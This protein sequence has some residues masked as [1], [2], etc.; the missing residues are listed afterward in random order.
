MGGVR[1]RTKFLIA[2]LLTSAG[3]TIGTL[4]VVQHTVAVRAREGIVADLQNSVENFRA[5]QLEREKNLRASARLLA[6]LPIVKALMTSRHAPTIQ[7][8]SEELFKLSERDLFALVDP[9]GQVVGF[10]T[11][12]A[13]VP[14]APIQ[15]V[16]S[17]RAPTANSF[18]WWYTGGHLYEVYL[19]PIY[20][21]PSSNDTLLGVIAVG[22]EIN[23][24]LA[25]QVGRLA[26]SEVA[27]LYRGNVVASTLN[28]RPSLEFLQHTGSSNSSPADVLLGQKKFVATSIL[29][30]ADDST[31]VTMV[32]MKSYDNAISFLQRLQ[33]LLLVI[34]IAAVLAG[35]ILVYFIARTFTR[36]LETLAVGV[37]ALGTGDFAFPLPGGGGGEVV[38]LTQAFVDMRDRLRAT[39][40]SLI[41]SERLATIGRMAG[42]ISHDLRHPLTAVLANAEFLAE[43]NLNTTQREELYMEIRVAVNRLTDLVDSLL[44]LSR[45]AQALTL[46][47]GPIEGSILRSIELIRAHPE[48]HKVSIEVE[49]AAGVD[50][51]VDGRK[52]ERVFYNLLLNA[53]Q[54]VQS[55]A[56]KVVISV[57]ES[58][59]GVEIRVR[60]NG[61]GVEPSIATKLFQPFVSVG[62]ENGTGLGLTIAQKIVQDHGGSLEV[63]WSSPGNTVMRIVLPQPTR[64]DRWRAPLAKS[65]L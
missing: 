53:C 50:T 15:H 6:D 41:E 30:S 43:A 35:S 34:G 42:S 54:A 8:A 38:K 25:R 7:D 58:S 4:L 12:P 28:D 65:S 5:E 9:T 23:G 57:T 49:G 52:M 62:K 33:R 17:Q 14:S 24:P 60:D 19:E 39:Q 10:H 47:E 56:G 63:E 11:N 48:F 59:A 46:T 32:V 3:L 55:R 26:D 29:L 61:P 1:L 22:Y 20:F 21:G 18:E 36:P 45:P 37:S 2:M 44:E 13:G 16:L 40:Q 64:S 27:V 51:R 31:P